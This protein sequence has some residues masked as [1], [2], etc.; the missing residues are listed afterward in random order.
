MKK[1]VTRRPRKTHEEIRNEAWLEAMTEYEASLKPSL[2]REREAARQEFEAAYNL[3][4]KS[5]NALLLE[6]QQLQERLAYYEGSSWRMLVYRVKSWFTA[7]SPGSNA[8]R[9]GDND[10]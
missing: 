1:T 2:E 7:S 6:L 8:K 3:L 10:A 5:H 4:S 9:R